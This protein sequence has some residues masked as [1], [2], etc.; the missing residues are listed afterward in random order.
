[1]CMHRVTRSAY[2]MELE[3]GAHTERARPYHTSVSIERA[4][5]CVSVYCMYTHRN[6]D[7]FDESERNIFEHRI[8]RVQLSFLRH[9][10]RLYVIR[11]SACLPFAAFG[12]L[13]KLRRKF[14]R[15]WWWRESERVN[16]AARHRG[17]HRCCFHLPLE[18]VIYY[19]LLC[20][21]VDFSVVPSLAARL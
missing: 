16:A 10:L 17:T 3:K 19:L 6:G 11:C 5:V 2:G 14:V 1:M 4:S 21:S 20:T 18:C 9:R 8:H 15:V 12:L 13:R 7:G